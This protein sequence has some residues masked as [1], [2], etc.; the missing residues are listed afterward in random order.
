[1]LKNLFT[2]SA[3]TG[4]SRLLGFVRDVLFAA[5][6]GAGPVADAFLVA[7]S[8]PNMFRRILA[9]GALNLAFVPI[10]SKKLET[11]KNHQEFASQ[12]VSTLAAV[13]ILLV[14]VAQL[15][16]PAMV[17][18]MASGYFGDTRFNTATLFGR[19][20]FP[21]IF[22]IALAA[23]LSGILNSHRRFWVAAA[24]PV[25]LN[26]IFV[27]VLAVSYVASYDIGLV[28]AVSVPV[29]GLAQ[30]LFVFMGIRRAGIR[31]ELRLPRLTPDIRHLLV[32]AAPAAMTGGVIQLNLLIGRQVASFEQGAV[33]W[34][35]YADR[36]VQ[37]PLGI[38]GVA[39]GVVLLPA[40]SR[41]L[42]A[43]DVSG[44]NHLFNRCCE[45]SL[46]LSIP[47]AVALAVFS[48]P[49][50][51]VLFERGAFG[52]HDTSRT[53]LALM[54]Y[55]CGLPA[56]VFQKAYQPLFFAREDTRTPFK[57]S[58]VAMVTNAVVAVGLMQTLGY[59]AAALGTTASGWVLLILFMHRARRLGQAATLDRQFWW[60]FPRILLASAAMGGALFAAYLWGREF[61]FMPGIRYVAVTLLTFSGIAIYAG[62]FLLLKMWTR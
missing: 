43:G 7:F 4:L 11:G 55:A 45:I 9:E 20:A 57:L 46:A 35:N 51:S 16:M 18:A 49:I 50:V 52:E 15:I 44:G 53:A 33:A 13:L 42:A 62:V 36:L 48:V 32:I 8:L 5:V 2:V 30:L 24:A 10:Y 6:L 59:V 47:A 26:I 38:V 12:A 27:H 60:S 19:I 61:F 34:L 21:Y 1:M 31:I 41:K 54:I 25:L 39:V 40:L 28:M 22:F 14:L 58:L 17:F 56:F 3:W 29:A 37:V 23:L